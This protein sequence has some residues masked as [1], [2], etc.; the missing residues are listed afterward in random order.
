[1][2]CT[3]VIKADNNHQIK[4]TFQSFEIEKGAD[5]IYD[6]ISIRDGDSPESRLI[7]EGCGNEA[8]GEVTSKGGSLWIRFRTDGSKEMSGFSANWQFLAKSGQI[9]MCY[10]K[11]RFTFF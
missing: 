3:W 1:M 5:C 6:K 9:G 11:R 2:D 8:P 10:M 4:L 7:S